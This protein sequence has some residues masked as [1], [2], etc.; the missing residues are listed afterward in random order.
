MSRHPTPDIRHEPAGNRFVAEVDGELC[1]VDYQRDGTVLRV[2]S[3]RVPRAVEG[4]GIA[5]ALTEQVMQFATSEGLQV[6][7]VCSYTAA[8]LRRHP[9]AATGSAPK[10]GP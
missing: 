8:Y 6:D 1:V 3:T 7:P 10:Q 9:Q 5:A 4:R 2:L